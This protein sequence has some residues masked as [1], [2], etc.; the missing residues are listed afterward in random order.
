MS[1]VTGLRVTSDT[2]EKPRENHRENKPT[3]KGRQ[4]R[5]MTVSRNRYGPWVASLSS[6]GVMHMAVAE[7][8]SGELRIRGS[9][10]RISPGAPEV[11]RS[12]IPGQGTCLE[13]YG[14]RYRPVRAKAFSRVVA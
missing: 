3:G 13:R 12:D 7:I 9:G 4:G 2:L 10:V 1:M 11:T 8:P 14:Q 6:H 5:A